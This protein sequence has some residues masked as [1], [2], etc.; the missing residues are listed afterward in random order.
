MTKTKKQKTIEERL[1]DTKTFNYN[2]YFGVGGGNNAISFEEAVEEIKFLISDIIRE[3]IGKDEGMDP[4]S[5]WEERNELRKK[6]RQRARK[7]GIKI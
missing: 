7:L 5:H 1:K 3:V 2:V 4:C 6:Q